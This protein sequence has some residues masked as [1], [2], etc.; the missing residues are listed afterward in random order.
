[1]GSS[2]TFLRPYLALAFGVC[3][4]SFSGIFVS[5]AAAPGAVTGFY[6]MSIAMGL[7]V[8]PFFWRRRSAGPVPRREIGITFVAGLFFAADVFFWNTGILI[9]GAANPTLLGNMAPLWV[10]LGGILF[11]GE[12]QNRTFWTGL[13][14]ALI[15]A[16]VILGG[17][18]ANQVGLGSLFGLMAGIFYGGYYLVTQRSRQRLDALSTFWLSAASAS[19][20][21]LLGSLALRQP[22]TGYAP[23]TY[24]NFLGLGVI[25]Q[26]AGQLA[27]S[28]ALG[29]LPASVVAPTNLAQ[30]VLTALLAVPLLKQPLSGWQIVGGCVVMAGVYQLHRG[31]TKAGKEQARGDR[32]PPGLTKVGG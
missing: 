25:V 6:R 21:L 7:L 19:F 15:G 31:R 3:G 14:L 9:S 30:P 16:A 26:V 32:S 1:M 17:D 20:F 8:V 11:F 22:L 5:W 12:R 24:L 27:V 29:Y 4:L 2:Q 18:T 13:L 10:G 28:Y 23:V